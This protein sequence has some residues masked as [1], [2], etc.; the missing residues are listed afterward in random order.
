MHKT[1]D[2]RHASVRTLVLGFSALLAFALGRGFGAVLRKVASLV[3]VVT[4]RPRLGFLDFPRLL[5]HLWRGIGLTFRPAR[6]T[7]TA[8]VAPASLTAMNDTF[9]RQGSRFAAKVVRRLAPTVRATT[10]ASHLFGLGDSL[11][12][13][14]RVQLTDLT[15]TP[16]HQYAVQRRNSRTRASS[17]TSPI[18]NLARQRDFSAK[19]FLIQTEKASQ[20]GPACCKKRGNTPDKLVVKRPCLVSASARHFQDPVLVEHGRPKVH[21]SRNCKAHGMAVPCVKPPRER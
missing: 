20:R 17:L 19:S 11:V 15:G 13:K 10:A 9:R 8:T 1:T 21:L 4:Q 18:P 12:T 14:L 7:T 2:T 3:A 5:L 16:E 6:L